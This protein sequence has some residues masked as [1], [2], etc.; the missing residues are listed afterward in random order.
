MV[1]RCNGG[2][3]QWWRGAMVE[4]CCSGEVLLVQ[5]VFVRL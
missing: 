5:V 3:V 1:V 2:E 4:R